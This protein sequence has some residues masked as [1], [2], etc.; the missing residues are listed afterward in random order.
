MEMRGEG[1]HGV[2]DGGFGLWNQSQRRNLEKPSP[3]CLGFALNY[4]SDSFPSVPYVV[5]RLDFGVH[6]KSTS[7]HVPALGPWV[8]SLFCKM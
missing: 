3:L 5:T 2:G 1:L 7:L 4:L 6:V 8:G